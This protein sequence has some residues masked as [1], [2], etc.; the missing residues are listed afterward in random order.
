MTGAALLLDAPV[1]VAPT[2]LSSTV[3]RVD[4]ADA[5]I[6]QDKPCWRATQEQALGLEQTET[7]PQLSEAKVLDIKRRTVHRGE[8]A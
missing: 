1:W 3:T 8:D 7:L 2:R 6:G 4:F 5:S